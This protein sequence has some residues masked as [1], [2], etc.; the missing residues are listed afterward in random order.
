MATDALSTLIKADGEILPVV[1]GEQRGVIF[2]V[3]K[4]AEDLM[5]LIQNSAPKMIGVICSHYR[6]LKI[7][8][9]LWFCSSVNLSD[10]LGCF[11]I[12]YS[13]RQLNRRN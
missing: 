8:L 1:F 10:L 11:V 2:N 5:L 6:F 4:S 3:L 9:N 13:K 7:N 12:M